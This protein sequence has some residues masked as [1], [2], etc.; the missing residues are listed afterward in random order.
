MQPETRYVTTRDG[1][2][3]AWSTVGEGPMD[4]LYVPQAISTMEHVWDHP[5]VTAFF[6]RLAS[7]SRLILFDRRGSGMSERLEEPAPLED[8]VDDVHAVLDAAGSERCAVMAIYEGGPMAMLFAAGAPERV[9]ALVLYAS[10]ARASY[11]ADYEW[12]WSPELREAAMDAYRDHWGQ[13]DLIAQSFAPGHLHDRRLV[14]WLGRMQ[15]LAMDPTYGRKSAAMHGQFDVRPLLPSI[16]VPT[17]VVHRRHDTA[18]DFRHG[19]YLAAH[20]PDA[21]LAA[22]EGSDSLPFLGDADAVAD[23]IEEFLTGTRASR[24]P[25]RVLATVLFTDIA[26]STE[27][28]AELG[29][30]RWRSLLEQHDAAV[31][32]QIARYRGRAVKSTGDGVLATFDG[33]ARAIRA[34]RAITEDLAQLGLDV[35]AGLHTGECEVIGDDVGGMAVHIAARVM[36]L[37]EP[38]EVLVSS[39]VRDL[40]VGSGLDFEPRGEHDLRG[41]PGPWRLWA[42]AA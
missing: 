34:A 11:V 5:T 10:F 8:Q 6:A 24:E 26:R 23:E 20:I 14:E 41:V 31:H 32:A 9:G 37:A 38:A 25:D 12:A 1:R 13:G 27:R 39:T 40:V 29:D 7:F 36:A 17:L 19:Q 30:A 3:I 15:R 4:L 22:L 28:A 21:R 33:P 35:R 18:I 2:A 42:V 16:R